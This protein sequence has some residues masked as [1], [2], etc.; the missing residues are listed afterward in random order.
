MAKRGS[1]TSSEKIK[2]RLLIGLGAVLALVVVYRVFLSGPETRPRRP[3]QTNSTTQSQTGTA[4]APVS[5]TPKAKPMGA[6]A[7]QEAM[8]Q[9]LL[10]DLTPLNLRYASTGEG[11]SSPGTRDNIFGYYKEPPPPPRPPDPPPP[12]QLISVQPQSAVA[13]TP[14]PVTLVI[15]GNK[16]PSD[17][18]IL[19]DNSP[20]ATKRLSETQLS[21]EI[22]PGDYSVPR[23]INIQVRSQSK[24]TENSNLIQFMVEAPPEP[25]FIYKGRLGSLNQTQTNYAVIELNST[26]ET[27]RVKVGETIMGIWRVDAILADR[28]ELTLTQNDIKRRVQLQERPK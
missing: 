8:M 25:Q 6:A 24:P 22:S 20:R 14:K 26:K 3:A 17:A 18:Q 15:S 9:A 23:G 12:V 16:I 7:Q 4:T 27:K 1:S 11:S 13:G 19:L 28:I 5:S 2:Q 10:S 21:T